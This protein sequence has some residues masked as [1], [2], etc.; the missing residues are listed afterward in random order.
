MGK[1]QGGV[2]VILHELPKDKVKLLDQGIQ[3]SRTM[4]VIDGAIVFLNGDGDAVAAIA[5]GFWTAVGAL[6]EKP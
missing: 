3:A 4:T 2:W 5:S 6:K 1:I